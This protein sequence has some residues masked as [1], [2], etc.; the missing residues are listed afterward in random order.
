MKKIIALVGET[1]SGKDTFCDYFK[2]NFKNVFIFRFSD[3]LTE[4]LKNFF[5]EIKKED[6][7]WLAQTLRQRF[8]NNVLG[9]F[10]KRK[11]EKIKNGIIILNGVR[12][13]EEYDMIK[14]LGGKIVYITAP[15]KLRWQRIQKRK[16][17]E[18][19]NIS[20]KK[21]LK[22]EKAKSEVFISQIGKIADYKIEN[23]GSK[24][25]FYNQIK[26]FWQ[27]LKN[28]KKSLSGKIY[29]F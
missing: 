8:G 17:K 25:D 9:K 3:V 7:Q 14:K 19:D 12:M 2:K 1:G 6:Q 24:K 22:L 27:N 5:D 13:K 20:Y 4:I 15:S 10:I 26:I 18:D 23:S 29:C 28:E 16:E 11:I 21:F